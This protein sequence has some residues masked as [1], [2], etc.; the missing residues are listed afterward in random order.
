MIEERGGQPYFLPSGSINPLSRGNVM[1]CNLIRESRLSGVKRT[2]AYAHNSRH[3]GT[4]IMYDFYP[5]DPYETSY[6]TYGL[7]CDS[8][9]HLPHRRRCSPA[10][11]SG[12]YHCVAECDD[13]C[14]R[15]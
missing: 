10:R 8:G 3:P 15:G 1:F 4:Y 5:P 12:Q 11:R 9:L 7:P 13:I 2:T 14:R 6:T